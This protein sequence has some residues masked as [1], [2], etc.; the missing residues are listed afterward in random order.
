MI[1]APHL[2]G[3]TLRIHLSNRF[4]SAPVTLGP[5]SLGIVDSGPALVA[6]SLR[7]VTLGGSQ[8]VTIAPGADVVSDPVSLSF[9][10]FQDLAVSVTV[11]GTVTSPTEHFIT[12]Q[13]SY[14][15]PAASGDH[16]GDSSG[17]AFT[18]QTTSNAS[19]GWYFLD[20]LD[21]QAPESVGSVVA[22][23]DS[24][25]DGFQGTLTPLN[26][27][28]STIDTN[29]RYPD[30][31]QRR[32]LA[33]HIPLSVLNAGISGNRVLQDGQIPM[34]GAAGLTRFRLD[35]LVQSGVTEVIVLE[36]INDIGQTN[37][38]TAQQLIDGYQTLIAQAHQAGLKIQLGTLTP[39]GGTVVPAYGDAAA[40]QLRQQVNAWIRSQKLSDGVIDFD[41][42]VRDPSDPSR[43]NPPYDGGDHL[44]FSLAG[45]QAMANA[46]NLG[47]LTNGSL[48][49][50]S[51]TAARPR[52]RLLVSPHSVGV[53]TTV[54]V[55]FHVSALT[56]GHSA[57]VRGALVRIAGHRVQTGPQ[58]NATITLR[59]TRA[60]LRHARATDPGY[61]SA[62]ATLAVLPARIN[63]TG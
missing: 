33:A 22:F 1:I 41:A 55:R 44:H 10:A 49:R 9:S 43:I 59:F 39:S 35:A 40:D 27:N 34:F 7:S 51:C 21:V 14:L 45:Y 38:I 5:V 2:G 31:L 11:P 17:A 16:S 60:G 13:T 52:L 46:V 30:D 53:R 20:G 29:G 8:T 57:L 24:I 12:R 25:T 6:G 3:Q 37:G 26:E 50:P 54:R 15:S 18:Q 4:G 28:L 61:I 23:G 63:V 36:G 32:L 62:E 56:A 42:A 19:V 48:R 47:S 58:G